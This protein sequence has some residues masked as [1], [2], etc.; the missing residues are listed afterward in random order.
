M[1]S[2]GCLLAPLV[3]CFGKK[4][5]CPSFFVFCGAWF[6]VLVFSSMD[7]LKLKCKGIF[8]NIGCLG[9]CKKTPVI[10]SMDEAS[11]GL[12][13]QGQTVSKVDGSED[14][15]SSSTFELDHS[16]A[17]SQRSIS[18]IGMPNNPS[19]SQCSGG[20]QSGAPEF[21]NHGL[22]LWNQIRQQ[23][24]GNKRSES[25]AEI[26]EPRIRSLSTSNCELIFHSSNA[27]YDNLLGNNKPYPQRI[28]LREMIDFLVDIWEQEGLYD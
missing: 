18:S 14:F 26:Q 21:V 2:R 6:R 15:W 5:Q 1:Y 12:R 23:W 25:I 28:P 22:L 24:V 11:K 3:R 8:C 9:C 10:I 7:K 17:H 19:D 27:N 20:S 16:A 13:T 4:P